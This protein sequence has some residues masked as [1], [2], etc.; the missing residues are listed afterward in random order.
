MSNLK[1][2]INLNRVSAVLY[3]IF[4]A[5][6]VALAACS[7]PAYNID[8]PIDSGT[9]WQFFLPA[10]V[11]LPFA[12]FF[13]NK[14]AKKM[15]AASV[16]SAFVLSASVAVAPVIFKSSRG[17]DG[18]FFV[19]ASVMY[20]GAF[21]IGSILSDL[22]SGVFEKYT[23]FSAGFLVAGFLTEAVAAG[24]LLYSSIRGVLPNIVLAFAILP[25]DAGLMFTIVSGRLSKIPLAV[26]CAAVLVCSVFCVVY[27]GQGAYISL[28]CLL[29]GLAVCIIDRIKN[30]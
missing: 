27:L 14:L 10:S 29:A 5:G 30:R 15:S 24:F 11:I 20:F 1:T 25:I 22:L 13:S 8:F 6:A 3:L 2:H 28:A 23:V 21:A 19:G 26:N 17:L 9:A 4:S 18:A 12:L 16:I 7:Y